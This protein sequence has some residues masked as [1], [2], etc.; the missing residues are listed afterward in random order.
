[1]YLAKSDVQPRHDG[2]RQQV[3]DEIALGL[4]SHNAHPVVLAEEHGQMGRLVR[5]LE[6]PLLTEGLLHV[7]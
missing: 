2:I 5:H 7:S 3:I 6:G 4:A 1:M